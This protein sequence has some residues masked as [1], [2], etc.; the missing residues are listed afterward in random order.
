MAPEGHDLRRRFAVRRGD[1]Y[2]FALAFTRGDPGVF[3]GLGDLAEGEIEATL[4]FW[5]RWS[6]GFSYSGPYREAV[7]RSALA[8]KL[9]AFAPSGAVIAAPTT[10]LPEAMGGPRNWDY[11]FC[12]LRDASFTIDVLEAVGFRAEASAF[13]Q[14]ILHATRLTHPA[15]QVLY[16]VYGDTNTPELELSHLEGY[17]GSRP[18]RIGNGATSQFQIDLYG[19]VFRALDRHYWQAGGLDGDTRRLVVGAANL[20]AQRWREPDHGI[21]EE[22]AEKRQHVH[23]KVMAWTAL[24][25]ALRIARRAGLRAGVSGWEQAKKAL[26]SAVLAHGFN[27]ALGSFVRAFGA[28]DVDAS[29]LTLPLV[30]FLPGDDPRMVGTVEAV[31]RSLAVDELVYRYRGIDD[32]LWG[33]EGAFLACSFW[34]VSSLALAGRLEESHRVFERLLA[35]QNDLGLLPEEIDPATGEFLGNF[36]QGLSH[37]ALINA[38]LTLQ[39]VEQRGEAPFPRGGV[40]VEGS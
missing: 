13:L 31:R 17:R 8:L 16:T 39:S 9:L 6:T 14:W 40:A 1:S 18:V 7:L 4:K 10:S 24:D 23:G 27:P 36:P 25:S 35:R 34:L 20:V 3:P 37:L 21:W 19:E 5:R 29:L 28:A 30:G 22:R 32:G 12:W 2:R 33:E 15:L 11:R 26:E 38:A